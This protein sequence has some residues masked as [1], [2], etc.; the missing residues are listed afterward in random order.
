MGRPLDCKLPFICSPLR[1]CS[2]RRAPRGTGEIFLL[3]GMPSQRGG[4]VPAGGAGA[5]QVALGRR[6]IRNELEVL[7][8]A[9]RENGAVAR[10]GVACATAPSCSPRRRLV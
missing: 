6:L 8:E 1:F 3:G 2:E 5:A 4:R 7:A 9:H 10:N